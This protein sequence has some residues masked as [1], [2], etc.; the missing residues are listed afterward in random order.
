MGY[1]EC[2]F[3]A[4]WNEP[5]RY[6]YTEALNGAQWAW[7]FLRRNPKYQ[8]EWSAFNT[9]WNT[10]EE[11]YGRP[12][13]RDFCAWKADP[14]AWVSS[15]ECQESDCRVDQDKVLIECA[16]GARWGFYKFPPSPAEDDPVGNQC[17]KWREVEESIPIVGPADRDWL[18]D[19][20]ALVALGF[21]LGLPLREQ[22]ERAKRTLQL[23]QRRRQKSGQV[24][25]VSLKAQRADLLSML[26]LLDAEAAVVEEQVLAI[27]SRDWNALLERA[28]ALRDGGYRR[29][30]LLPG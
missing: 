1:H 29:L 24:E 9:L 8:A 28:H 18:G 11:A 12:P 4:A 2:M 30:P 23:L 6:A 14:R 27:V 19:N 3:I 20:A 5:E 17:L 16:V 13:N 10:L 26:R 25:A 21:N 22:L 15:A 7:E